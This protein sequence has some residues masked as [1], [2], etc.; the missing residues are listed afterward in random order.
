MPLAI[1]LSWKI[2][3]CYHGS[4]VISE[5]FAGSN[6]KE[7][8]LQF[9]VFLCKFCFTGYSLKY[10]CLI[11]LQNSL[12]F[13]ICRENGWQNFLREDI[14]QRNLE[15]EYTT[16]GWVC[17]GMPS[18]TETRQNSPF[19]SFSVFCLSVGIVRLKKKKMKYQL[20]HLE[21]NSF[22]LNLKR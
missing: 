18:S 7:V 6:L 2:K 4:K 15:P 19:L 14:H 20:I 8:T 11:T 3:Q 21:I 1:K 22:F 17:P 10:S 12:T 16:F 5:L 13:H 9:F